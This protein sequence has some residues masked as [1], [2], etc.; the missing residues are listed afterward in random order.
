[1]EPITVIAAVVAAALGFGVNQNMTKKR[2]GDIENKSKKELE[3]AEKDAAK[4]LDN[5]KKEADSIKDDLQKAAYD[6]I[7]LEQINPFDLNSIVN[8]ILEIHEKNKFFLL[9]L[10]SNYFLEN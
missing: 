4:L 6:T 1:M 5:A 3:K 2:L 8:K 10:I 9:F 7:K